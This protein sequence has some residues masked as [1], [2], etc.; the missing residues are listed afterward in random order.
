M[1]D[2]EDNKNK[3]TTRRDFIV[4]TASSV[5]AVG[6]ACAFWP[7]IDSFNPSADVLALSSIEVDLSN[8]AIGQTVTVKWQGKPIFITNRT[9]DE[10]A[11]ARAVKMSELIDPERDEVRVKAGHDNWLVT[12]GICTHL[13]CVPLS[14]KGEYNGWFCPCHGS[15]YDSSGRVRKG[16]A[17]LNL[18]V[19]P[20]IFISDKK[21]R[22]G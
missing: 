2:T 6:A 4:L 7:I 9:H 16:P 22:I 13:G 11:A 8:I 17:P 12:I 14:H 5:A 21:I 3:Q 10:I 18:A 15:Q 20:Y 19:P 1:S